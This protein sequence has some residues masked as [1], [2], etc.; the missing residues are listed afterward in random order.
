MFCLKCGVWAIHPS[1]HWWD[2]Y[3][4]GPLG[5]HVHA[6]W[7]A[8]WTLEA[9]G[10]LRCRFVGA[11]R[12]YITPV[13]SWLVSGHKMVQTAATTTVEHAHIF[14]CFDNS[15]GIIIQRDDVSQVAALQVFSQSLG[16]LIWVNLV[17]PAETM[18]SSNCS[19]MKIWPG[20]REVEA[21][22]SRMSSGSSSV[23]PPY[24]SCSWPADWSDFTESSF[25]C[26][27]ELLQ[28]RIQDTVGGISS[29]SFAKSSDAPPC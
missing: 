19:T 23:L 1:S 25:F 27:S 14:P 5:A 6:W 7:S 10:V 21:A 20:G 3:H 12:C 15:T 22:V 4:S 13:M 24:S 18:L 17:W 11:H 8:T 28:A 2:I 16:W 9:K 29:A 26:F